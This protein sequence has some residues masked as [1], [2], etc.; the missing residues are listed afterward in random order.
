MNGSSLDAYET[1]RL[2]Y[3]IYAA[4]EGFACRR[5][6]AMQEVTGGSS[7]RHRAHSRRVAVVLP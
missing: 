6:D 7:R 2:V 5:S 4:D 1:M 3:G